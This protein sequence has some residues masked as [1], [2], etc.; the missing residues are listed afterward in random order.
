MSSAECLREFVNERLSAAAEEI[1]GAFKKTI[2]EY[3]EEIDR[4]RRL[5]DA[6]LKREIKL[7]RIGV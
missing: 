6:V 3:E 7:H 2:F 4:Q 1:F 5:L